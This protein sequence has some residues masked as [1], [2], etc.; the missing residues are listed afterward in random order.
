LI[1]WAA[2][3]LATSPWPV[4]T[5]LRHWIAYRNCAASRM[6]GLAPART[7]EPGYFLSHD[8]DRDGIACEPYPR[9]ESG[10]GSARRFI[11]P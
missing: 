6:V 9:Q 7:G 5:T 8:E 11:R 10:Q 4:G 1:A 2:Y 3:G